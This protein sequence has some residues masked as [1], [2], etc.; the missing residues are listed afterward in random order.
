MAEV[1]RER[2]LEEGE[3]V[4]IL[5]TRIGGRAGQVFLIKVVVSDEIGRDAITSTAGGEGNAACTGIERGL[6]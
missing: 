6:P 2:N 3:R 5:S 1:A 4:M